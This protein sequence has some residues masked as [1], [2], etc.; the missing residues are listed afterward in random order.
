MR[1]IPL[2]PIAVP[3]TCA[4]SGDCCHETPNVLMTPEERDLLVARRPDLAVRFGTLGVF[5]V[6]PARPCPLLATDGQGRSTCTVHDI[7][8]YNCR[9]FGCYRPD[10]T[11]EI[12]EPE[13]LD[14][15]KGRLGC[16]NLSDRIARSRDVRR[17]YALQQR[18]A[19]RWAMRMGWKSEGNA[20][21]CDTSSKGAPNSK[22][23]Y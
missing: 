11:T 23:S 2:R 5:V 6:L 19:Q 3:W 1:T 15:D 22:A 18:K 14:L 21:P 13:P 12:F 17:A 10:P 9:R 4:R 16:A 20:P 8:P 7:R